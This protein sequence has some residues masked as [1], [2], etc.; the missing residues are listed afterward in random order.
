MHCLFVG[1][2][3]IAAAYAADL[4]ESTLSLA[5]V[6]DLDA[7]RAET[8][9]TD[10]DA[11]SFTDLDAALDA[12]DAPVV[13]NLTSHAAHASITETALAAESGTGVE[14]ETGAGFEEQS[15]CE[16]CGTLTGDLVA[17]NGQLLCG[18]C[19]DI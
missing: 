11:R 15:I 2:G 7:D 10:Y 9:A 3:D 6:C 5:G 14:S 8:L 1:A 17:F 19:R 18:D 13:V 12:V 4:A 16:G